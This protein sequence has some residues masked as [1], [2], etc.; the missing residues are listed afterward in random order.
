MSDRTVPCGKCI[1][2]LSRRQSDWTVRLSNEYYS[3][4]GAIFVT[5]TYRDEDI[6]VRRV[7]PFYDPLKSSRPDAVDLN[8]LCKR[9][10]QLYLKRLRKALSPNIIRFFCCGEYGPKTFRPHYHLIL[11]N[12]PRG[13]EK[14]IHDCWKKGYTTMSKVTPARIAYVAKY[15]ACYT[16]LP[17]IYKQKDI[18]PFVTCSKGIG[19]QYLTDSM[20]TYHRETLSTFL[21]QNGYKKPLPKYYKDRIFDDQMK[22][23]ISVRTQQYRDKLFAERMK[24]HAKYPYLI[25]QQRDE[26]IRRTKNLIKN[27]IL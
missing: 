17:D 22:Y 7:R 14:L 21:I 16:F 10:V 24:T 25:G 8:V 23:D 4:T 26:V 15:A 12:Y 27:K 6:P 13:Y 18:R 9:D 1:P 3:S 5:L 20:V 11:F 19:A 2:C